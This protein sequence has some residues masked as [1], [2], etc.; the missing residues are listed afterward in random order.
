M[1][2]GP[3]PIHAGIHAG[4]ILQ[5]LNDP[6]HAFESVLALLDEVTQIVRHLCGELAD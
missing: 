3:L 5:I 6:L 2:V 4:K 1:Q